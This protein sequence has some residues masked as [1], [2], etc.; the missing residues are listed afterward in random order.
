MNSEVDG[1]KLGV[2]KR[3]MF[4]KNDDYNFLAYNVLVFLYTINCVEEKKRLQDHNKL[5]YI[6]PLISEYNLL[7][8]ISKYNTMD[9]FPNFDEAEILRNV[10]IK[11]RLR[12]RW[13]SSILF[14]LERKGIVNLIKNPTRNC[15][16]VWINQGKMPNALL[17]EELFGYEINN[18]LKFKKLYPHIKTLGLETFLQ[19]VFGEKG[20]VIWEG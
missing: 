11:S 3:I 17:E 20:V 19:K 14:A 7:D 13:I 5:A 2:K 9:I 4:N 12:T 1:E 15:I 6:V 8:I 18:T 10:Y 16:D